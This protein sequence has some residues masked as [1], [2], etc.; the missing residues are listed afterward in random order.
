VFL[1]ILFS[2]YLQ[3]FL[4]KNHAVFL[5]Q[6]RE[7]LALWLDNLAAFCEKFLFFVYVNLENVEA[8]EL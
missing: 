7:I 5:S 4:L 6:N 1:F 3:L 8:T 2:Y